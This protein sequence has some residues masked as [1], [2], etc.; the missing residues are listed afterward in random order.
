MYCRH[1]DGT[2]IGHVSTRRP[3]LHATPGFFGEAIG[4]QVALNDDLRITRWLDGVGEPYDVVTDHDLN[5]YGAHALP[6]TPS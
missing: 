4:G 1:R 5:E 3:V 2:G 6:A